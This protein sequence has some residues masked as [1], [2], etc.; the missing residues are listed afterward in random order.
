MLRKIELPIEAIDYIKQ[1]LT[2][3]GI[4]S[5]IE[6][7]STDLSSGQIFTYFPMEFSLQTPF[8]FCE[9]LEFL[10]GERV[11]DMFDAKISELIGNFLNKSSQ[12]VVIFETWWNEDDP[13]TSK[14]LLQY[15]TINGRRYDFL[16]GG[17]DKQ[18]IKDY[19]DDAQGYPSVIVLVNVKDQDI[20]IHDK[21]QFPEE[22]INN[23]VNGTEFVIVGA[24]DGEGYLIWQKKR[25]ETADPIKN[26]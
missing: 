23:L 2:Q 5:N 16:K 8:D 3:G 10:T 11:S 6:E 9:S 13:I 17:N 25:S 1:E 21:T 12:N 26:F 20:E 18:P 14:C 7:R 15:F 4:L 24:F 22:N 19:M